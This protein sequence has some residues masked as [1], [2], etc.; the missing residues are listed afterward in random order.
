MWGSAPS[1]A[2][3]KKLDQTFVVGFD[4]V[5]VI[6]GTD[7]LCEFICPAQSTKRRKESSLSFQAFRAL[8]ATF[9]LASE[10]K[11]K[12]TIV[13]IDLKFLRG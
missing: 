13:I 4:E 12:M 2:S 11:L 1:P 9:L 5:C 3:F 7:K 8:C 6:L 10:K